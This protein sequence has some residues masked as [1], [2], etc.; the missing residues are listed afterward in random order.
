MATRFMS[1]SELIDCV[2]DKIEIPYALKDSQ[3]AALSDLC[4]KQKNVLC[5]FPTGYGKS[6]VFGVALKLILPETDFDGSAD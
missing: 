3:K 2:K 6:E 5:V 1:I 4:I